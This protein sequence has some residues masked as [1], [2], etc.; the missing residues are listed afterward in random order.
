[1][2]RL[3]QKQSEFAYDVGLLIQKA[4]ELGYEVTLAEAERPAWVAEVYAAFDRGIRNS[5]HI[6]KLAI[7]LNLFR[8]GDWLTKTEDYRELGEYWESL[9]DGNC[10]GGRFGDGNH[11]SREHNGVR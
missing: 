11:F 6:Q 2:G 4:Y 7:D 1:M 8:D 3:R 5:L 9:R 10:W